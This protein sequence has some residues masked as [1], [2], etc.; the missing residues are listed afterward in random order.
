MTENTE[1]TAAALAT[2]AVTHAANTWARVADWLDQFG[3]MLG[4]DPEIAHRANNAA[5]RVSDVRTLLRHAAEADRLE[6]AL[7]STQRGLIRME[8]QR[9]AL[10]AAICRAAGVDPDQIS[11]TDADYEELLAGVVRRVP[12]VDHKC[13]CVGEVAVQ[14]WPRGFGQISSCVRCG[15][16]RA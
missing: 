15:G 10:R 9:D 4:L 5:L 13:E 16:D 7:R 1:L 11:E 8:Q 12:S 2:A 14:W 6:D 3:T